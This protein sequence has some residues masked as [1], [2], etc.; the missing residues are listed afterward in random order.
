MLNQLS[1]ALLQLHYVLHLYQFNQWNVAF[2]LL[3][4]PLFKIYILPQQQLPS[5]QVTPHWGKAKFTAEN[6]AKLENWQH[7]NQKSQVLGCFIVRIYLSN[8]QCPRKMTIL[9]FIWLQ[10][11]MIC[12][13]WGWVGH[14]CLSF[15]EFK[16]KN[17]HHKVFKQRRKSTRACICVRSHCSCRRD[18]QFELSADY[19]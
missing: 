11:S 10:G 5:A 18:L 1:I 8:F 12:W 6:R 15:C 4:L 2:N 17:L 9:T 16:H 19:R 14:A 7:Q 3:F 13:L